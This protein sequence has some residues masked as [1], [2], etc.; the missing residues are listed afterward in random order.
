MQSPS[1]VL[2]AR[3]ERDPKERVFRSSP[4]TMRNT[5]C[6]REQP[7]SLMESTIRH[8][9]HN[10]LCRTSESAHSTSLL[11]CALFITSVEENNDHHSTRHFSLSPRLLRRVFDALPRR[12]DSLPPSCFSLAKAAFWLRC[13]KKA[14]FKQKGVSFALLSIVC[15]D[16]SCTLFSV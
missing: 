13:E 7:P 9:R 5:R 15:I 1:T 2:E 10:P 12:E 3:K 8:M 16:K 11:R 6:G 4:E 14:R